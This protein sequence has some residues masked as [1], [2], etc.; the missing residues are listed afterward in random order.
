MKKGKNTLIWIIRNAEQMNKIID[1]LLYLSR[2]SRHEMH[3]ENL[4]ISRMMASRSCGTSDGPSRGA[5]LPLKLK[6]VCSDL[7]MRD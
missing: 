4:D 2:I 6:K 7:P 5:M 3:K 1:D